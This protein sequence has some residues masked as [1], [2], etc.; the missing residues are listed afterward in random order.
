[1]S[2]ERLR[3]K[4]APKAFAEIARKHNALLAYLIAT[5]GEK[6]IKVT[7]TDRQ[8]VIEGTADTTLTARVAALETLTSGL[9]RHTFDVCDGGVAT[10]KTFLSS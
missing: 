10:S 4:Q 6:G 5:R 1:M 9:T 7:V 2:L 8:I 3:I